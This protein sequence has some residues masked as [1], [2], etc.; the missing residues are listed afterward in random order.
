MGIGG[1]VMLNVMRVMFWVYL[2]ILIL[3]VAVSGIQDGIWFQTDVILNFAKQ[4]LILLFLILIIH[5]KL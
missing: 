4:R 1:G 5:M 2:G 3:N